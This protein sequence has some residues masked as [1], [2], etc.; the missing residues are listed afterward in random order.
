MMVVCICIAASVTR[1]TIDI[2]AKLKS[3]C[4]E[5]LPSGKFCVLLY[6]PE[7]KEND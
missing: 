7:I 2:F 4:E 1:T 6:V 5:Q 3:E